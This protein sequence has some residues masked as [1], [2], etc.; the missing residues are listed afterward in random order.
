VDKSTV[1]WDA[2]TGQVR[3]Q[4]DFHTAATLDVDWRSSVSFASCSSD[5]L[6]HVCELGKTK[7]I[8]TFEGHSDEVNAVRWDPQGLLLASSSD[9]S[10]AKVRVYPSP[11]LMDALVVRVRLILTRSVCRTPPTGMENG[12]SLAGMELH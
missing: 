2:A 5:K 8:M 10:T 6:I 3:Q 9:D 1:I 7:P 4:F 11:N 12:P